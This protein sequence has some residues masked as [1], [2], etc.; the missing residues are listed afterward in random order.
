MK[1]I[2]KLLV[3]AVVIGG[4]C[5][6]VMYNGHWNAV[7]SFTS[8]VFGQDAADGVDGFGNLSKD[9]GDD[10]IDYGSKLAEQIKNGETPTPNWASVGEALKGLPAVTG[11]RRPNYQREAFGNG[12]LDTDGNGCDTRND[13]L[14]R[15][16]TDTKVDTDSCTVLSGTLADP[17]TASTIQFTRGAATSSKVQIDHIVPLAL[18]WGEGAWK[19]TSAQREQFANDP[20]NLLAVDG[21]TNSAKSDKPISTWLPPSKTYHCTY[22]A[23]Y[24]AVHDKYKLAMSS[25]DSAAAAKLVSACG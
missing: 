9:V 23:L 4:A 16:L 19:W 20:M 11:E 18:A 13:I 25:S 3:A 17:Y 10:V 15:D 8:A 24:V 14:A 7:I 21:P 5:T 1:F 12:W 2:G 6:W 22:V